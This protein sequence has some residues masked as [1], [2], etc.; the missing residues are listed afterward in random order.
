MGQTFLFIQLLKIVEIWFLLKKKKENLS[1]KDYLA[2]K[3]KTF[4]EALVF[5]DS[6]DSNLLKTRPQGLGGTTVWVEFL[7][8]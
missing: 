1:P 7:H 5:R 6:V 4:V 3:A 8:Y 2:T